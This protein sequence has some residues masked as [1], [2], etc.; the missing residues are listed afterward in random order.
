MNK[1]ATGPKPWTKRLIVLFLSFV[2]LAGVILLIL[3]SKSPREAKVIEKFNAHRP[4]YER[5]LRVADWGVENTEGIHHP[6]EGGVS[7]D[8]FHEYLSLLHE[9]GAKGASRRRGERAQEACVLVWTAGWAGDTR[10]VQICWLN[11]EPTNQVASLDAFY[12]T[13][14][15]R[16]PVSRHIDANWYLWADW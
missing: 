7:V 16:H 4:A 1:S 13:P 8:R 6:P 14:K 2:A 12:L 3:P 11:H 15:P 5:L 10:H 9:V